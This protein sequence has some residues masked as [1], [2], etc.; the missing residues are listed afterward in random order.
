MKDFFGRHKKA[1]IIGTI[2][3]AVIV[4]VAVA[5]YFVWDGSLP[6]FQD[7]TIELGEPL[8]EVG[9]FLT[10][11]ADPEKVSF[12]TAAEDLDLT[13]TGV[14]PV[15]LRH[16]RKEETVELTVQDTTAPQITLRDLIRN[17]GYVPVVQDFVVSSFDLSETTVAFAAPVGVLEKTEDI[18]VE[19]VI[20]DASGNSTTETAKLSYGWILDSFTLELGETLEK[21]DILV[22]GVEDT[23]LLDQAEI[24]AVDQ[25]GV[26]EYTITSIREGESAICKVTVVDTTAPTLVLKDL[27]RYKG[28]EAPVLEDLVVSCTDLSGEVTLTLLTQ[29]STDASGTQTI[30]VEARDVYG[31]VT[32]GEAEL[33]IIADTKPPKLTGLG[34]MTVEKHSTPDYKKGVKATDDI[35]GTVNFTYDASKVNTGKAGTYYVTYAATDRSGNTTSYR[36]KITV[37]HDQEDT[38]AMVADFAKE[39]GT[40]AEQI[41]DHIRKNISYSTS[42][43]DD[44]PVYYG[45]TNKRGNCFVH[46]QILKAV[47]EYRGYNCKLIWVTNKSHYWVMVELNGTWRHIDS[48]PG[49]RHTKYSLMNDEQRY[50]TLQNEYPSGRDWDRSQWPVA[51]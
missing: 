7:V 1:W 35:D 37:E 9:R 27:E 2:C 10:E 25:G 5:G 47:L 48:T 3:L 40:D 4:A 19:V 13:R 45:L 14:F 28:R 49:T 41:R 23:S 51:P 16:G 46:A 33:K 6:R 22:E 50:E 42:W 34:A 32:V 43:G 36:R 12:V 20:T 15:T 26:G 18:I 11:R 38:N 30:Q 31:N 24:D 8:P 29:P 39:C 44:D 17:I 21:T